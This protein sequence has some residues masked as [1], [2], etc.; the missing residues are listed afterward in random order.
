MF[1]PGKRVLATQRYF[2]IDNF[3]NVDDDLEIII[4]LMMIMM[5]MMPGLNM[6]AADK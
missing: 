5:L 3:Y 1:M 6:K 4:M 2:E